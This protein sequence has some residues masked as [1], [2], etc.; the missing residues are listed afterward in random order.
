M[1]NIDLDSYDA[2]FI[3]DADSVVNDALLSHLHSALSAGEKII[4]CYN[5]VGNPGTSWF[6]R[7][8]GV[9]R[10]ISNEILHPA[11]QKLKLS[12][13]LTG[14]G[15]CFS[16]AI[17]KKYGWG[18][19]SIGED[20]EYYA[21]LILQGETIGYSNKARSFHQESASLKQ[22]TTQRMRWSS[23]RFAIAYRYGFNILYHGIIERD[24]VKIDASL[25]LI[26]P[27]PSLGANMTVLI[28]F[29]SLI[30]TIVAGKTFYTL[31]FLLLIVFQMMIFFAG[32]MYT[33]NKFKSFLSIFVAPM[34]LVWKMVIDILSILGIGSGKWIRTERKL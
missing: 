27:N 34:F 31:W 25:P 33:E 15:M 12:S 32:I 13:H 4:Q 7:L 2:V 10:A 22:A 14:N 11:K 3:V 21:K 24:I 6:T 26:F 20:W 19:F 17:L 16:T 5:G 8:L 9:S 18:A 23:G 1:L 28:F 30:P 29:L